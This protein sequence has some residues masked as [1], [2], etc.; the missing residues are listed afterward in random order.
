MQCAQCD[1]IVHC[2]HVMSAITFCQETATLDFCPL[3]V[4]A[5]MRQQYDYTYH[6]LSECVDPELNSGSGS[7]TLSGQPLLL[8]VSLLALLMCG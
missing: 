5:V 4:I 1:V 3:S 2:L 8:T 6:L 7:S